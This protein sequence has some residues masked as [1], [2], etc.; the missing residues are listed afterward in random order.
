M[1][2]S[3]Y[4]L[5]CFTASHAVFSSHH[6]E[7]IIAARRTGETAYFDGCDAQDHL[8]L[9]LRA[10]NAGALDIYCEPLMR[11]CGGDSLNICTRQDIAA[12]LGELSDLMHCK[13]AAAA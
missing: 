1:K 2:L 4:R 13:R 9:C 8:A 6:G 7:T 11:Q 5:E 3:H 12:L 10:S